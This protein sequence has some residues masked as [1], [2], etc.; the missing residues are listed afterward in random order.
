MDPQTERALSKIAQVVIREGL[1]A[2][3]GLY[4]LIN[5][6]ARLRKGGNGELSV[7]LLNGKL[8]IK[9]ITYITPE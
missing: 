3:T 8:K 5:Y 1:K 2:D 6:Y 9:G 7:K 4:D